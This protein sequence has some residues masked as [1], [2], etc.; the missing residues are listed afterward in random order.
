MKKCFLAMVLSFSMTM[1]IAAQG[2]PVIDIT[3][4]I[5]A[6]Q[7][8]YT[9]V[10]QLNA[11]Y[12]YIKTS[13]DQLQRQIKN[14]ESFD[15]KSLNAKDPLGS[16][17]SI[18]TY[19]N[20][21]ITYEENIEEIINRKDIKIGEGAYSLGDIFMTPKNAMLG[22]TID[23]LSFV[24]DPFEKR[25]STEEKAVF[26]QK[27]GMSYG[28]YM[29]INHLGEAIK[30]KSAEIAGYSDSL[31]KNLAEDREKLEAIASDLFDSESTIQQQ[32]INN[33]LMAILAQDMKTQSYL[34]SE[35]ATQLA[36]SATQELIEKQAKKNELVINDMEVSEALI[37]ILNE[38]PASNMYK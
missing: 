37:K 17:K 30:K 6:I 33:A 38:M 1:G 14:F 20:R 31:Q 8:G 25:L 10:E 5:Q 7:N 24:Y 26:H 28:H 18:M 21:M 23:G 4:V 3:N 13:Y 11:M 22:M 29:R 36:M 27:F 35:I 34:L 19:G 12:T 32:Q 9:L 2:Y 15:F 16:W